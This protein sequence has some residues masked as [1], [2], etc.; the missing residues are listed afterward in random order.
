MQNGKHHDLCLKRTVPIVD[1]VYLAVSSSNSGSGSAVLAVIF[2]NGKAELWKYSEERPGWH[3]L[4]TS[5]LCNSARARV[6]SVCTSGNFIIWCEERPPSENSPALNAIRN[7][8][9]YCICKRVYAVEEG[10]VHLGGVK[11]AL[12]NNPRYTVTASGENVYL[13]PDTK[14]DC[15]RSISRLFLKWSPLQDTVTV[16]TACT[17]T[18]QRKVTTA[19]NKESDFKKLISDCVGALSSV[20]P[21]EIWAFCA[22][23]CGG[24]M[25]LLSSG[26][27]SLLQKDGVLRQVY[28]LADNCLMMGGG[29]GRGLSSMN[30]YHDVLALAVGKTLY[31]IDIRCGMELEKMALKREGILFVNHTR[32]NAPHL[33]SEAGLFLVRHRDPDPGHKSPEHMRLEPHS[34]LVEAVFEEAC[35]HYQRRS[36]SGVQL[37]V[38]KLKS[39]GMFQ[40]P[41]ALSSI[42]RDYL[43]GER[44][45]DTA[46]E[47]GAHS[48]LLSS[49][50]PELKSLVALEDVKASA[51]RASEKELAGYCENLVREE[52]GR[53][54]SL[55]PDRE[56][57]LYL[58]A[59]FGAFPGESWQALQTALQL[60]VDGEGSLSTGARPEVWKVVLTPIQP[61]TDHA[62]RGHTPANEAAPVFEL[63]C[64]SVLHFQPTWLPGFLELAQQQVGSSSSPSSS[65]SYEAKVSPE[66]APLFERA[67]SVLPGDEQHQDLGVELLL[68]SQSPYGIMRALRILIDQRQWGRATR[69][70]EQFCRKS[71]RLNKEIFSALL[72]EVSQ[73]RDLDPYLDLLWALCPEDLTVT[74]I[75]NILLK[76][77][78]S[79][80][81]GST[82]PFQ[83][84]GSQLTVGL[85]KP[86]LS[87]VLE[88]ESKPS[89]RYAEI[90]QCPSLPFPTSPCEDQGPLRAGTESANNHQDS[91]QNVASGT[92]VPTPSHHL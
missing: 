39:G 30:V 69:V 74:G 18:L 45:V 26:W 41:I 40:A 53:L 61:S 36:L 4:H 24:L 32:R 42:L 85:L 49:L 11:I 57:V 19:T 55:E 23:E 67:L 73:H 16:G 27:I 13:L 77:L 34:L 75:L 91:K 38:E 28:K 62:S 76:G 50:E 66:S 47:G 86:L 70:A 56:N 92:R 81:L 33:L 43:K 88:R 54:L 78:S 2:Q 14:V 51:A 68:S 17:G 71:A 1:V 60:A 90:L 63:L 72:C 52:V 5:D 83:V 58:N 37:T 7:N 15:T 10:A 82:G 25:L 8:P 12:H 31:L 6:V 46:R 64:R 80:P 79:A 65:W 29:G 44:V 22:T 9:R 84:G 89:H 35:R 20:N 87:R 3:L 48:D 59:I 21:P